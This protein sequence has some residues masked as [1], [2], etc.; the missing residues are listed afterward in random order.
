MHFPTFLAR[1]GTPA[2]NRAKCTS[3]CKKSP[4]VHSSGS[5]ACKKRPEVHDK[6]AASHKELS[7]VHGGLTKS[8]DG[9]SCENLTV[10]PGS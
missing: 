4:E 6:D 5:A 7:E 3:P 1:N 8:T 2:R 10:D 9:R